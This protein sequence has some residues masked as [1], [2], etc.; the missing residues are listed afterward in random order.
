MPEPLIEVW[1]DM[2]ISPVIAIWIGKQIGIPA[3][4]FYDLNFHQT[5][6]IDVFMIAKRH[7]AIILTKDE[8]FANLLTRFNPPPKVI[9]LTCGNTSNLKLKSILEISL[10]EAYDYLIDADESFIEI[11]G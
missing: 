2:H 5:E 3:K 8:D 10:R 11:A 7:N 1:T 6:D 4:S 9:Q